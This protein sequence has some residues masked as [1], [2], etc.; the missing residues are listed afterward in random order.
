MQ[1]TPIG[2][3]AESAGA[4]YFPTDVTPEEIFLAIGRLRKEA[5]DEIERLL[6][7]LDETDNHMELEPSLGWP[8]GRFGQCGSVGAT[9]D[10]EAEPEH[11]EDGADAEGSL[12]SH[13]LPSGAVSYA[14]SISFGELDVEGEHDG[15]EPDV[16][17]EPSL[18]SSNDHHG[19]GTRYDPGSM[20]DGEGPDDDLEPSLGSINPT[21]G[22]SPF[23]PAGNSDDR[24]EEHDGREPDDSGIADQDGLDEQVPFR[25]C[26]NVGMV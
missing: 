7:F 3:P 10:S 4:L 21:I 15:K 9:D 11:D 18:G 17:D 19:T 16:D 22:G 20:T 13:E 2:T 25:D 1:N 14:P 24:E 6:N 8:E 26:Q 5:R 12:G 23:W